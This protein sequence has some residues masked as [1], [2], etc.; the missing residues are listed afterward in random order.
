MTLYLQFYGT[1]WLYFTKKNIMN[2]KS[3]II[4]EKNH[5]LF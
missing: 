1:V 2:V 3:S 5:D 4:P